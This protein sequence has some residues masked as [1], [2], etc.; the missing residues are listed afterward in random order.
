[1]KGG[2]RSIIAKSE[3]AAV[4]GMLRGYLFKTD[5]VIR[6]KCGRNPFF[7]QNWAQNPNLANR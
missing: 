7:S 2:G 1:M 4:R 6:L 3:T 5:L